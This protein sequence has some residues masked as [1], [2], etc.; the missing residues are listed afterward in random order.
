MHCIV[1]LVIAVV[2]SKLDGVDCAVNCA[3]A[4]RATFLLRF[5][6]AEVFAAN[7]HEITAIW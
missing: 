5:L 3:A 2:A 6:M 1:A 7:L 4:I